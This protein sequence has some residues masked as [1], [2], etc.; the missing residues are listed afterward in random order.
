MGIVT[1]YR[2]REK[3]R[4]T[5]Y[6]KRRESETGRCYDSEPELMIENTLEDFGRSFNSSVFL[7]RTFRRGTLHRVTFSLT[8]VFSGSLF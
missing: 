6:G 4:R 5:L 2:R 3:K 8:V 1:W 7:I